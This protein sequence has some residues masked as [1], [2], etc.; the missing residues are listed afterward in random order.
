[1]NHLIEMA[2]L[3]RIKWKLLSVL[4]ENMSHNGRFGEGKAGL[5]SYILEY[6]IPSPTLKRH[7]GQVNSA[8]MGHQ[9]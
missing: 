3:G 9:L 7:R 4:Q 5:L 6:G 8:I 1:V 2:E